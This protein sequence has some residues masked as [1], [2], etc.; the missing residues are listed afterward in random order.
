VALSLALAALV[1]AVSVAAWQA[2]VHSG[3][4]ARLRGMNEI[5]FV[6]VQNFSARNGWESTTVGCVT[7]ISGSQGESQG[8][9]PG[10]S[11]CAY[12]SGFSPGLLSAAASPQLYVVRPDGSGLRQLTHGSD[13]YYFSPVW[14]P[15]GSQIAAFFVSN[16]GG[17][18][19]Q[20]V[21]MDADGA[22]VH[23]V[24]GVLLHLDAFSQAAG[25]SF[26]PNSRLIA[27]SPTGDQM[28]AL[29]GAGRYALVKADGSGLRRF[30]A[31]L[32][33]WS[34]DGHTLAYYT[35]DPNDRAGSV[36]F[37]R[38]VYRLELLDTRTLHA[39]RLSNLKLLNNEALAWSPDGRFLAVSVFPGGNFQSQANDALLIVSADGGETKATIQW[40]G[41][42][43]QQIAWSPD[44][45]KLAV[46]L[47]RF[48]VVTQPADAG[49][50]VGS[51]V[52][53][54]NRDGANNH[55]IGMSDDGQPSWA[56][57]GKRLVFVS[58]DELTL[59]IADTSAQAEAAV[60]VV[61]LPLAFLLAPS[62][63]PLAGI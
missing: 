46:V 54:I 19:A 25:Q 2:F 38:P 39:R 13:G 17:A 44:G 55:K 56:P 41:A 42:R 23:E 1:G 20:L 29:T 3:W 60:H 36:F 33:A 14:S 24:G 4:G 63:S 47:Q 35:I 43:V 5:V 59:M 32:P 12:T 37:G 51:E 50:P 40:V 21:V 18:V 45:E 49:A 57:D 30:D 15:D 48:N 61:P 31:F 28:V 11:S 22:H 53:V 27:W 58:A 16:Q 34:P 62:W 26:S 52:W 6:G 9:S 10:A 7:I 8:N